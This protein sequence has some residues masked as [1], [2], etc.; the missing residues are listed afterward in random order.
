MKKFLFYLAKI[1]IITI[2]SAIILDVVYTAMYLQC[3]NR[4]KI[5]QLHNLNNVHYDV[6]ILGSSRANNHFV[7]EMFQKK[8]LK[9]F[10]YGMSG[11]S[12]FETSLVLK[13]MIERKC[14]IKNLILDADLNLRNDK[15]SRAIA[16]L[17]LPYIHNSKITKQH[18]SDQNDFSE[19]YY[20]PFYRYMKYEIRIGFREMFMSAIHKRTSDMDNWGYSQLDGVEDGNMEN[21]ISTFEPLPHNIY[22]EEIKNICKINNIKFIPIM[23]PVCENTVGMQYFDKVKKAYPE[24]YNYENAVI[25]NK[26]FSSCGH[27]NGTGAKLFTAK[28][29]KDFFNK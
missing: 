1:L 10:N 3:R 12:L 5:D 8:G 20:I 28:I 7:S 9:T 26:Y 2:V 11:S 23:S 13:L 18:F 16:S 15:Q 6:V 24:I 22:Y 25:E 27:M 21:D 17:F 29:L 19:I 14:I 4:N